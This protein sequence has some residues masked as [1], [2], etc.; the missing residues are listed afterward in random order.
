MTKNESLL[1]LITIFFTG[2]DLIY[3]ALRHVNIDMIRAG[4]KVQEFLDENMKEKVRLLA[5]VINEKGQHE[6]KISLSNRTDDPDWFFGE[7]HKS[8]FNYLSLF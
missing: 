1:V 7:L 5:E 4:Q 8:I 3:S 2:A 6:C